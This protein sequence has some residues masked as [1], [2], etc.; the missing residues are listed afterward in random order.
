[1]GR[2]AAELG[3]L[4]INPWISLKAILGD[5]AFSSFVASDFGQKFLSTGADLTRVGQKARR[6]LVNV[7]KAGRALRAGTVIRQSNGYE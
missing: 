2:V 3:P 5:A 4:F 7:G 6:G 1:M